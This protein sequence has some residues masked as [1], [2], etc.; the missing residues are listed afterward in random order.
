[1]FWFA[2]VSH[3][4]ARTHLQE[5]QVLC[6]L[7][8][9][10]GDPSRQEPVVVAIPIPVVDARLASLPQSVTNVP[11]LHVTR[12]PTL[13]TTTTASHDHDEDDDDSEEYTV[14]PRARGAS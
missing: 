14:V 2:L 8:P 4:Y 10:F 11:R 5:D 13:T 6:E 7:V 1:M 3:R 9:G 12:G